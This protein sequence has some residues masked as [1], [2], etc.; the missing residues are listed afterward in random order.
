MMFGLF[1]AKEKQSPNGLF[2]ISVKIGRGSNVDM[3]PSLVGAV[4]PVFAAAANHELAA[5][6]AVS[7][8]LSQGFEFLDIQGPIKQLD[9]QQWSSYV[10]HTWPEFEVHFPEQQEVLAGVASGAVFFGPFAG[11]EVA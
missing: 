9:P 7:K 5:K 2:L 1:N 6:A 10:R 3:P 4:V 8:L 11:Y